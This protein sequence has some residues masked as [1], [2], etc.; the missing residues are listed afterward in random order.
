MP[1]SLP[2]LRAVSALIT[3]LRPLDDAA[4]TERHAALRT[5]L[6]AA[7]DPLSF[8]SIDPAE[9]TPFASPQSVGGRLAAS[10]RA[11][12]ATEAAEGLA[13]AALAAER[14]L[15]YAPHPNQLETALALLK[16]SV[17]DLAT[18]EGKT[19]AAALAASLLAG[20][21][22]G[23]HVATANSY[24]A[25]RDA[26]WMGPL[27]TLLGLSTAPLIGPRASA[28]RRAAYQADITYATADGLAADILADQQATSVRARVRRAPFALLLDEADS[29]LIDLA[30][31]PITLTRP[32]AVDEPL[33]REMAD[34]IAS[35]SDEG[36]EAH[37]SVD[38][39]RR[40]AGPTE[41][42][43]TLAAEHFGG[44]LYDEPDKVR[45]FQLAIEA[46][47]LYLRDRDYLVEAGRIQP[48]DRRTGRA[49]RGSFRDGLSGAI[50][51]KEGLPIPPDT[52]VTAET[53][54]P[55]LVAV[56]PLVAGMSG[57]ASPAAE[58]LANAYGLQVERV[59]PHHPSIRRDAQ[60]RLFAAAEV[61]LQAAV[62]AVDEASRAGRPVLVGTLDVGAAERVAAVIRGAGIACELLT[63]RDHAREAEILA[64]AGRPGAVTV[65]TAIA[66]R[67]VDIVLGGATDHPDFAAR[68]AQAIEAGGLAI[69][70]L[71]RHDERR[72]DEQLKGRT[73]RQGEP[74]STVFYLSADDPL[75]RAVGAEKLRG[76]LTRL[77]HG[78]R[79]L[80]GKAIDRAV[81]ASQTKLGG[82]AIDARSSLRLADEPFARQRALIG[83]ERDRLLEGADPLPTVRDAL[84]RA[85]RTLV[86]SVTTPESPSDWEMKTLTGGLLRIGIR[87]DEIARA[88][89]G[90]VIRDAG[91]LHAQVVRL[92]EQAIER[93]SNEL[94]ALTTVTFR[95][96]LLAAIDRVYE[97][98]LAVIADL[99]AA[100]SL[101]AFGA[102]RAATTYVR[103]VAL[104]YGEYLE[105]L[106]R[107]IARVALHL[108]PRRHEA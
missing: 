37:F 46:R 70:G 61:A 20:A 87:E 7:I 8:A 43:I 63:A 59:L 92:V 25:G 36:D 52:I 6:A 17:V 97:E 93:R 2:S 51:A 72:H 21:K 73:A 35:F 45:A 107:E 3:G 60:D 105:Q 30:R 69:I 40:S 101:R 64:D 1:S 99:R 50:A 65:A 9:P 4:L 86:E 96:A 42:G 47:A 80:Y 83:A 79:A 13:L 77:G 85:A 54:I 26:A 38:E 22:R 91:E 62:E 29:L 41:A 94:G 100:R 34:L 76:I 28:A 44:T 14:T 56:Y 82:F 5:R 33:L 103:D 88:A 15:G 53:T 10:L 81:S 24:L 12:V 106:A 102:G 49:M 27:Y 78:K 48:I 19:L 31:A 16:G 74:G 23:V 11:V 32:T 75:F 39:L 84:L 90:R 18:G 98:H 71:G 104:L 108:T 58:E 66:G 55:F 57:S 89:A 67:G 95:I 68:R